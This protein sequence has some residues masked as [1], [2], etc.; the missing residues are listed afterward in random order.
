MGKIVCVLCTVI[1]LTEPR[2]F[3]CLHFWIGPF[4]NGGWWFLGREILE[5]F[6]LLV[7]ACFLLNQNNKYIYFIIIS[8]G[9]LA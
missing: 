9:V 7:E 3:I 1:P 2:A 8:Y 5:G 4:L 6:A